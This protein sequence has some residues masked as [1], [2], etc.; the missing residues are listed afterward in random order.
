MVVTL[1]WLR[2]GDQATRLN[3]IWLRRI[4]GIHGWIWSFCRHLWSFVS[5]GWSTPIPWM[6]IVHPCRCWFS[7]GT[8]AGALSLRFVWCCGF[9][10]AEWL[11]F[12]HRH[13]GPH[14]LQW[15]WRKSQLPRGHQGMPKGGQHMQNVASFKGHNRSYTESKQLSGD[16]RRFGSSQVV[17]DQPDD[18]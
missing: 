9:A 15:S 17:A 12:G 10:C 8:A 13:V 5:C 18:P 14:A 7:P 2:K 6:S 3:Y 16:W 1:T 11:D 4:K